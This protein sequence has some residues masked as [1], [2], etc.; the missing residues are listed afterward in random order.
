MIV[1]QLS[2]VLAT[3]VYAPSVGGTERHVASLA[4]ALRAAGHRAVVATTSPAPDD[5]VPTDAVVRM[6]GWTEVVVRRRAR[7]EQRFHPPLPDPGIV[8]QLTELCQRRG[9]DVL[10]AHGWMAHSAV[11]VARREGIPLVVGLHDYGL[12]CARRT[13]QTPDGEPCP[14]PSP[15]RCGPCAAATYGQLPGRAAATALRRGRSWWAEVDAFVANSEPVAA[16][17]RAAGVACTVASPWI[18]PAHGLTDLA[19][20]V[21]DAPRGPFALYVGARS[22]HKGIDVLREAWGD[23]GPLPLVA[24]VARPPAD[25]P[26]LPPATVVHEHADPDVV[27]A[28]MARAAMV[29]VPST[30]PEPFGLVA[31]EA[32]WAGTPVVASAVG[33]LIGVL[34]HGRTGVLVPPDDPAALREAVTSLRDDPERRTELRLAGRRRAKELDGLA[35][36]VAVYRRVLRDQPQASPASLR[37]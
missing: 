3:D 37:T 6:A 28:T 22:A 7:P 25:A 36:V 21:P 13:R 8:A 1:D 12:D 30:F 9:A 16:A 31:T 29:V 27:L 23:G 4:A 35:D 14:G 17:A 33:G 2:I 20:A 18:A 5:E 26:A 19:A 11:V 24:L 10:H 34:D 15:Q 32:M